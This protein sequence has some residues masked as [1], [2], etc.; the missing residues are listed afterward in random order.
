LTH[1][2]EL[3][4]L[5][6]ICPPLVQ[7]REDLHSE[8]FCGSS[9]RSISQCPVVGRGR[10]RRGRR[11]GRTKSRV[12]LDRAR[13]V[14]SRSSYWLNS[15]LLVFLAI[16]KREAQYLLLHSISS[17]QSASLNTT[18]FDAAKYHLLESSLDFSLYVSS[19]LSYPSS[20]LL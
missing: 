5:L 10:S 14:L 18:A 16:E 1:R 13:L 20:S 2:H 3:A 15:S 11:D 7:H 12:E 17:N 19:L 4:R 9:L 8:P 6:L